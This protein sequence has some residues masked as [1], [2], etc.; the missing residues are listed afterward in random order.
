MAFNGKFVLNMI[1]FTANQGA[2]ISKLL[3]ATGLSTDELCD[4]QCLVTD[5]VYN[6]VVEMGLELT[7]DPHFGLHAAENLNL[8]AAGLIGQITQTCST[9]KE[10]I[11]YCCEFANLGC[12]SLP[13]SLIEEDEF[14]KVIIKPN[15]IWAQKSEMAFQQTT[16][17]ILAFT[18]KELQ[19]L[20]HLKHEP[21]AI[22]LPW[23]QPVSTHEFIRVLG[24]NVRFEQEEIAILLTK[25][26]VN[27]TV[28][29]ADFE[30]LRILVA[31]AS[32]K[33]LKI[34]NANKAGR[35]SSLVEQ[36]VLKLLKP[37]FPSIEQVA[38]HLNLSTRTLQRKLNREGATYLGLMNNLRFDLAKS[39][40]KRPE[41]T[42]KEIAYLLSYSDA[43][44]FIRFF[45]KS[46]G[47]SPKA[48][49]M[50]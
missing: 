25:K 2:D 6:T 7:Q 45:R 27:A 46:A 22:H 3:A 29:N 30:L 41:L 13:M 48:F 42:I 9:I 11:L 50:R 26:Q 10:A 36:S 14:F 33:S 8:S 39:Y 37:E 19:S 38:N 21:I 16:N 12:S 40:L 44:A 20:T 5:D 15:T 32:E 23:K 35:F 43:S 31:H 24:N 18:I 47:I 28:V 17:G 34:A 49:R 1:Q 4:D